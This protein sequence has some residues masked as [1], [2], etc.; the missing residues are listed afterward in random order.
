MLT[1]GQVGLPRGHGRGSVNR[2]TSHRLTERPMIEYR[3]SQQRGAV[4][5]AVA[6]VNTCAGAACFLACALPGLRPRRTVAGRA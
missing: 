6:N 2:V 4:N 1:S 3:Y 5:E